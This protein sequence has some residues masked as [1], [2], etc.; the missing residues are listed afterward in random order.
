LEKDDILEKYWK[1]TERKKIKSKLEEAKGFWVNA[2]EEAF[3]PVEATLEKFE[4]ERTHKGYAA[5]FS[6]VLKIAIVVIIFMAIVLKAFKTI[7]KEKIQVLT[8]V[9]HNDFRYNLT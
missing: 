5:K 4:P 6:L 9:S 7:G 8:T 1:K 2:T 3:K